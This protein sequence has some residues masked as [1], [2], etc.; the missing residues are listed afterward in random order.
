MVLSYRLLFVKIHLPQTKHLFLKKKKKEKKLKRLQ[1]TLEELQPKDPNYLT[2]RTSILEEIEKLQVDIQES[3]EYTDEIEYI[4]KTYDILFDYYDILENTQNDNAASS[5]TSIKNNI[6]EK[7]VNYDV[8]ST[9][10]E[11]EKN[12]EPANNDLDT[13]IFESDRLDKLNKL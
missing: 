8:T 7:S 2:L 10:K 1:I 4:G 6:V 11:N 13:N 3:S 12:E 5:S 9:E